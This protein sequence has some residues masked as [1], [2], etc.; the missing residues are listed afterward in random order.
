MAVV[1]ERFDDL[2][3]DGRSCR[4]GVFGGTFDPVH[5]GHMMVAE[6]ARE[7]FSLDAVLFVPAGTP[8]FKRGLQGADPDQRLEMC[9]AA[10]RGNVAFDVSPIEVERAGDTYTVDT[11]RALRAHYGANVELFFIIGADAAASLPTWRDADELASLATFIVVARGEGEPCRALPAPPFEA[12]LLSVPRMDVS[13]SDI[14]ARLRAGRSARYLMPSEALSY[15][16]EWGLYRPACDGCA[17]Y[18]SSATGA[19]DVE[20]GARAKGASGATNAS[21]AVDVSVTGNAAG[22]DLCA[23]ADDASLDALSPAF[24]EARLAELRSRV[25]PKRLRHILGVADTAARIAEAYGFDPV[26][27]RLAGLLHDWDKGYNDE[28][29]RARARE[30]GIQVDA[31]V[32]YDMPRLLHGP[33]AAAALGRRFPQIPADVLHAVACHTAGAVAM[34]DLDRAVFVADVIEPSRSFPGVD[35]L[36]KLVG[37]VSLER[38]FFMTFRHILAH[39]VDRGM[40]IHPVTVD[41]WNCGAEAARIE[42]CPGRRKEDS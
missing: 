8:V 17:A 38:L 20:R 35:G 27:A 10:V 40:Q 15:A 39:L 33:T 41:V 25:K 19:L 9:R 6:Q 13:S 24:Y 18:S 4:L 12:R 23:N 22:A 36:R 32:Y 2:G 31:C 3:A 14:R 34:S 1:S 7:T 29:I 21:S 16:R 37:D 30:L 5:A 28:E 42:P 11:L 26:R